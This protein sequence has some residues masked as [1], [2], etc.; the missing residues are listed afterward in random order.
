MCS[1][2]YASSPVE[3]PWS[4]ARK[5]QRVELSPQL[6]KLMT[7]R[8]RPRHPTSWQTVISLQMV[9]YRMITTS[10][11]PILLLAWLMV[12]NTET[13]SKPLQWSGVCWLVRNA[14][15]CVRMQQPTY[16]VACFMVLTF[17]CAC[18]CLPRALWF[19]LWCLANASH[20]HR[21]NLYWILCNNCT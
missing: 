15:G 20:Y 2:K 13:S 17:W 1:H 5:M 19:M 14:V 4:N 8:N 3:S 10:C 21:L 6:V 12:K 11:W 18:H 16:Y 7:E 9:S